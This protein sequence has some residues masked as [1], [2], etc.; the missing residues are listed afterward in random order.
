MTALL[1]VLN[2]YSPLQVFYFQTML[3]LTDTITFCTYYS[4]LFWHN[5]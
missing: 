3:D 2:H 5:A 1:F 4:I